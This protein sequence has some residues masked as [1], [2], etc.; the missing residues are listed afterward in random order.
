MTINP[1][2]S[3]FQ[4]AI[5]IGLYIYYQDGILGFYRGYIA[6]MCTYVPNSAIWW[7]LYHMYQGTIINFK[8]MFHSS[9]QIVNLTA[10]LIY[11]KI[12]RCIARR[13]IAFVHSVC[14]RNSRRFY[15]YTHY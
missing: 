8:W 9:M 1:A 11:R 5:D 2:K 7:A 4:T 12:T 15:H 13:Y 6:S 14:C 3:K 10:M